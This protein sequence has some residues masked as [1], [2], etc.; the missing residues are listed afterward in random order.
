[1]GK[2]WRVNRRGKSIGSWRVTVKGREINL[3]TKDATEALRRAK[4]AQRGQWPQEQV[5]ADGV[6]AAFDPPSPGSVGEPHEPPGAG[7]EVQGAGGNQLAGGGDVPASADAG[8]VIPEL[9]SAPSPNWAADAAGA[10]ADGAP[11]PETGAPDGATTNLG[12]LDLESLYEMGAQAI[13]SLQLTGQ[14][15]AIQRYG[16]RQAGDVDAAD[17]IRA[18]AVAGWKAQLRIWVPQDIPLPPW[19]V[20][21]ALTAL[22]GF[23]Q[24]A[25]SQPLQQAGA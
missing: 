1:M 10:A 17:G 2:L 7:A 18:G 6:A 9:V 4:L 3:Q 14:A 19:A 15:W 24:Y 12:G 22:C 11:P 13:V 23:T 5:A 16:K 25:R 8:P 21:V 20:G